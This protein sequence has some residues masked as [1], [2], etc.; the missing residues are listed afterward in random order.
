MISVLRVDKTINQ[1]FETKILEIQRLKKQKIDTRDSEIEIDK[2][3]FDLYNLTLEDRDI[4][5]FI[6]IE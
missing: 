6:E 2:M 3:I 5:G 4:I 1:T